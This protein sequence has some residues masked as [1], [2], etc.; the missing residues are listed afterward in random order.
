MDMDT[1]DNRKYERVPFS[2][3]VKVLD[4]ETGL[5]VRGRSI[6]LSR[7]GIGFFAE[8][9]LPQGSHIRL[10]LTMQA[11]GRPVTTAVDAVVMRATT[12]G[13]GGIMGAQFDRVLN[14]LDQSLLC[15]VVDSRT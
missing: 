10:I 3:T 2:A 12:E 7:G 13:A 15:E 6:D 8:R 5:V 11:G 9:F 14:P 1:L 4:R